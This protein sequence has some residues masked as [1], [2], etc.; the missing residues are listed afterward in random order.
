MLLFFPLR[1][2]C[3][4]FKQIKKKKKEKIVLL[5]KIFIVNKKIKQKQKNK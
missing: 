2:N 4:Y 5:K 3:L 1:E